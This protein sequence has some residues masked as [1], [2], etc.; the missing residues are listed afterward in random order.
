MNCTHLLEVVHDR[1]ACRRWRRRGWM[2]LSNAIGSIVPAGDRDDRVEPGRLGTYA[3]TTCMRCSARTAS[4]PS[5]CSKLRPLLPAGFKASKKWSSMI[6]PKEWPRACM[7]VKTANQISHMLQHEPSITV[8]QLGYLLV[9]LG[10]AAC[11]PTSAHQTSQL[12]NRAGK[13]T[14]KL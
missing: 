7:P 9:Q 6:S 12:M 2:V 10:R 11:T 8:D 14:K 5:S 1:A 3:S 13:Q 4:R